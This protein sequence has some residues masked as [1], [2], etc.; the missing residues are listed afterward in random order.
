MSTDPAQT[1]HW[2]LSVLSPVH[3]D[4]TWVM[5][6][7][8]LMF[9]PVFYYVRSSYH[10]GFRSIVFHEYINISLEADM[11]HFLPVPWLTSRPPPIFHFYKKK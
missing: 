8:D 10:P 11:Y 2:L 1:C 7:Q 9:H 4:L 6:Y 3:P 5:L